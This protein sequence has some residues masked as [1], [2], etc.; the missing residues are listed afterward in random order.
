MRV[1]GG[2]GRKVEVPCAKA[3]I[4]KL[5]RVADATRATACSHASFAQVSQARVKQSTYL[6][7]DGIFCSGESLLILTLLSLL[8]WCAAGLVD[9]TDASVDKAGNWIDEWLPCCCCV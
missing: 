7:G 1:S 8:V 3:E 9:A 4:R 2:A 6:G 5:R